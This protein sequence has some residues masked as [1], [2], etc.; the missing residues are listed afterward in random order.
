MSP[1]P[2]ASGWLPVQKVTPPSDAT[3]TN[4]P[5]AEKFRA[6]HGPITNNDPMASAATGTHRRFH[7]HQGPAS[8]RKNNIDGRMSTA[9]PAQMPASSER[10]RR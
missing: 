3:R 5:C 6:V 2:M 1:S 9:T 7:T 4:R 10:R 8:S